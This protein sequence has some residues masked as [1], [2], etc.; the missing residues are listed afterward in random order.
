M[1][2]MVKI[3]RILMEHEYY[4]KLS[5]RAKVLYGILSEKK[6]EAEKYGWVDD[7]GNPYVVLPKRRMQE[8][9]ACSRYRLD[10]VTK[11]LVATDLIE[12]AYGVGNVL[13]RR[14]Y[15]RDLKENCPWIRVEYGVRSKSPQGSGGVVKDDR[16]REGSEESLNKKKAEN[17]AEKDGGNK[18]DSSHPEKMK[19]DARSEDI[20]PA[21]LLK[22]LMEAGTQYPVPE[23]DP[24]PALLEVLVSALTGERSA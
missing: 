9:L 5:D 15:V 24:W 16:T 6:Q 1:I 8:E 13:E 10:L 2:K 11:E 18:G 17:T 4:K 19:P 3:P 21:G 20:D 12:L 23:E 22:M 14:I 7:Q